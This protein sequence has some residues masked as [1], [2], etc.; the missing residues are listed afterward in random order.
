MLLNVSNDYLYTDTEILPIRDYHNPYFLVL[1]G[2]KERNSLKEILK[3]VGMNGGG[4]GGIDGDGGRENGGPLNHIVELGELEVY[5][6]FSRPGKKLDVFRV[7]TDESRVVPMVSN[8]LFFR[9][10]LY[11]AEHDIPYVQRA[12]SDLA[13]QGK[14]LLDTGGAERTLK[15]LAYDIETPS[16][17][18]YSSRAPVEIIGF[19]QF[20]VTFS[21]SYDLDK[22]EFNFEM[23]D[24]PGSWETDDINQFEA[25]AGGKEESEIILYFVQLLMDSHIISGHNILS[26]DNH[27]LYGRIKSLIDGSEGILTTTEM[28]LLQDYRERYTRPVN[29]FTYGRKSLGVNFYP[30]S[31]DTYH[32]ALRFYRFLTSFNLKSLAKFFGL[33]IEGRVH[34]DK[35][36]MSNVDWERLMDYSRHDVME[37]A[38]LT[39][40]MLQQTLPLAFVTGMA[41]EDL[42]SSGTTKVWDYMTFIRGARHKKVIP[43]TCRAHGISSGILRLLK[44]RR[45]E[46]VNSINVKTSIVDIAREMGRGVVT[47]ETGLDKE[48][49]RVVK[50]GDEMP[51]WV[52]YPYI[53]FN[54]RRMGE[55]KEDIGYH[56]P[57]GMTIQ[58]GQVNS[59]FIPWWHMIVADVGAMYPT[60][61]KGMNVCADTV[62]V[63]KKG[64]EPDDWIWLK[65]ITDEFLEREDIQ[66][67]TVK[68]M[69]QEKYA[70]KGFFIGVKI[71][72]SKGMVNKAMTGILSLI[73]RIKNELKQRKALGQDIRTLQMMYNS[74]KGMRNAGT[75]G[76][77]VASNV[78]CRQFNLW[79]GA[80]IT[81]TGQRILQDAMDEFGKRDM[82]VVYG[83]T[84]GIYVGCARSCAGIPSVSKVFDAVPGRGDYISDPDEVLKVIEFLNERWRG[85]LDYPGFELE[86]EYA[87]VMLFVKHKNYLIW[88]AKNGKLSMTTKGNNFKGSDKAP[89][90]R[91]VL[92]EIMFR[93]LKEHQSWTSEFEVKGSLKRSIT[94]HTLDIVE[95]LDLSKVDIEDL[96]LI[97]TV[98][99]PTYYK[100]RGGS[101][102]VH[103]TRSKALEE[104]IGKKITS[105]RKFKFVVTKMPLKGIRNP[106]KSGIKP[107][108]YM[109]PL[110]RISDLSNIDLNWYREMIRNYVKGAFGLRELEKTV[111]SGLHEFM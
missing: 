33:N 6:S 88:N 19:T 51:D 111:Q 59:D 70:D 43:P 69:G 10:G 72:E 42:L 65:H 24:I 104:L 27:H 36:D 85:K 74:L 76:I 32:A 41:I 62:R 9:H 73:Y 30:I 84:D 86:P 22:E 75:H 77:L 91:K 31:L 8:R 105:S 49:I 20:D 48:L 21:S 13:A 80:E 107:I 87:D 95:K 79:G 66:F 38:G 60:I 64:E 28:E 109:Y 4:G 54:S 100:E 78:S 29:Y 34:I 44:E 53:A 15:V 57:G 63:A 56:L 52:N 1:G 108:D 71:S 40:I 45:I 16:F 102:S 39:R 17:E 83:D 46:D 89:I 23:Q 90:A 50:Y 37:Q 18:R 68:E 55:A 98:R 2:E 25:K 106:S 47:E 14:W 26:F 11:T 97:Q 82:R 94:R 35:A 58:P 81:T 7:F 110:E 99:P 92:E 103:A 5:Q 101:E 93:V 61:L 96:T 3:S 12:A 67:R